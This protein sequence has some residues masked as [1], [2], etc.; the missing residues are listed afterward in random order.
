MSSSLLMVHSKLSM[1]SA[2]F[3]IQSNW[4]K[5]EIPATT[6]L[7]QHGD[8]SLPTPIKII[9]D[10]LLVVAHIPLQRVCCSCYPLQYDLQF[11]ACKGMSMSNPKSWES[12]LTHQMFVLL[13]RGTWADWSTGHTGIMWSSMKC[14]A[15]NHTARL[16]TKLEY[17]ADVYYYWLKFLS[18]L[19]FF[20]GITR[21]F[22]HTCGIKNYLVATPSCPFKL[23]SIAVVSSVAPTRRTDSTGKT[24]V[25]ASSHQMLL[26]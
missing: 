3:L 10:I 11:P 8:A 5:A 2:A 26:A 6:R 23:P 16:Y 7:A 17:L 25:A 12:C 24:A 19:P 14:T 9:L 21:H 1:W 13:F 4:Q 22:A 15:K 20:T 18:F